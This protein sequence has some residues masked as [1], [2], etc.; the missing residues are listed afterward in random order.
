MWK[1]TSHNAAPSFQNINY[2]QN[3]QC[4]KDSN[5]AMQKP[6]LREM[7]K[8]ENKG[9]TMMQMNSQQHEMFRMSLVGCILR[10][11]DWT[12]WTSIA[13]SL[14]F[15]D[16]TRWWCWKH[17]WISCFSTDTWLFF[18]IFKNNFTSE[19][20]TRIITGMNFKSSWRC[21][22]YPAL[23]FRAARCDALLCAIRSREIWTL[24]TMPHRWLWHNRATIIFCT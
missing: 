4:R 5:P 15:G 1:V 19:F 10:S 21:P 7:L 8:E 11:S 24:K 18:N 12:S 23:S 17:H 16:G 20:Q 3:M 2:D 22:D 14:I 9:I 6:C 13:A